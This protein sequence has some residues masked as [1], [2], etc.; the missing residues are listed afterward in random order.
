MEIAVVSIL[1]LFVVFV[2]SKDYISKLTGINVCAIC[3]AVCLTWLTLL[4]LKITSIFNVS[5]VTLGILMGGS[6]V[7]IMY[8]LEAWFERNKYPGYWL[9]RILIITGGF[10]MVYYFLTNQVL[11]LITTIAIVILAVFI[12][13]IYVDTTSNSKTKNKN[14]L[15]KKLEHCCD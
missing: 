13:Y 12:S 11:N 9:Y 7:G 2:L 4:L 10:L 14:D 3:C 5:T 15:R 6:V 8:K 1:S